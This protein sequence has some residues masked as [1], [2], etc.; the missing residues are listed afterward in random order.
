[1]NVDS[2]D[3]PP[4]DI[5]QLKKA[6]PSPLM[7]TSLLGPSERALRSTHR[8]RLTSHSRSDLIG[9]SFPETDRGRKLG[10]IEVGVTKKGGMAP[11]LFCDVVPAEFSA[12]G[13]TDQYPRVIAAR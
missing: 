6:L 7:A 3:G 10:G 11:L 1:M 8:F 9:I 12:V 5:R 2:T 13:V 4:K